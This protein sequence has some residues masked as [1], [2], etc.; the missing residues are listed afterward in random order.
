MPSLADVAEL[1]RARKGAGAPFVVGITGAVAAGKSTFAGELKAAVAA[2]PEAP[3]VE[4]VCTDG[5]LLGNATLEA[6]GLTLR[7]G[8]PESYDA[9]A[10]RRTLQALREG[11]VEFPTYSHATY[12]VDPGLARRIEPP[13]VLIVEGL[14]LHEP[15]AAGLDALIY[16][17]ADE[18]HLEAWFLDRFMGLW[19]DAERD[20][21][22]FYARFRH[23]SE[24]EARAFALQV[25]RV[26]N[27]PN[28]RNHISQ[29]RGQADWVVRKGPGHEI[30][31]VEKP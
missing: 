21:S 14:G 9:A 10:M 8:F 30:A 5:F 27:L 7:K 22:S 23:M 25:W 26:I 31:A 24:E 13:D 2:W 17:D 18:A 16:L 3:A 29:A 11:P 19:R 6:R 15:Q 4:L 1:I 28:L 20:P 12:D